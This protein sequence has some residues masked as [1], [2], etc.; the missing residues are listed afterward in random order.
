M[1]CTLSARVAQRYVLDKIADDRLR[2]YVVWG[3]YKERETE[4]DARFAAPFIPDPRATHFWTETP[5]PGNL[6][7]EPL[8][9]LG[10]GPQSAWDS[11]LVYAPD[12][13]W[14]ESPPAPAHFMHRNVEGKAMNG[15]RLFEQVRDLLPFEDKEGKLPRSRAPGEGQ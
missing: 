11:F 9:P 4:A 15:N 10:L 12:A 5:A 14:A 13:R 3:S 1:Y 8:K 6:F 2:V 7:N